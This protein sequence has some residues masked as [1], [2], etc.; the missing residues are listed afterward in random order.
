MLGGTSWPAA[1]VRLAA[2]GQGQADVMGETG[3]SKMEWRKTRALWDT[4]TMNGGGRGCV[5]LC[6]W[7]EEGE[8]WNIFVTGFSAPLQRRW[9]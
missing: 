1:G 4:S 5:C 6:A 9:D 8:R 2:C 7:V 3:E